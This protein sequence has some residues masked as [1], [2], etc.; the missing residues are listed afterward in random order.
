MQVET[1][2]ELGKELEQ[3]SGV[4]VDVGARATATLWLGINAHLAEF[5][6]TMASARKAV[7]EETALAGIFTRA[8]K[9]SAP[10]GCYKSLFL[11]DDRL[12]EECVQSGIDDTN[13]DDVMQ[14]MKLRVTSLHA[15]YIGVGCE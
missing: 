14:L 5:K 11:A 8:T 3:I 6:R 2:E 1:V 7:L 9:N 13:V 10:V 12:W 4:P 15:E